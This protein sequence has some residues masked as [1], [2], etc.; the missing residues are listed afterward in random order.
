MFSMAGE[1]FLFLNL[2]NYNDKID[3]LKT[4]S[5]KWRIKKKLITMLGRGRG[6]S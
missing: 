6:T 4:R 2:K 5:Y 3:G 1:E